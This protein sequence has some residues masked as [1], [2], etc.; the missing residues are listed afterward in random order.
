M[1]YKIKLNNNSSGWLWNRQAEPDK[2]NSNTSAM[3]KPL[4]FLIA[5]Q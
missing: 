5:S 4:S 3:L 2:Y 1:Y